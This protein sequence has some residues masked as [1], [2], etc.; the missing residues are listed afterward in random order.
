MALSDKDRQE[1]AELE[2]LDAL[3]QRYG[4]K[5]EPSALQGFKD[6]AKSVAEGVSDFA[7]G[8]TQGILMNGA[9]E[10][11]GLLT[12]LMDQGWKLGNKLGLAD[13]SPSQVNQ[14]LKDAGYSGDIGPTDFSGMFRA[15][16]E[17]S[18]KDFAAAQERSPWLY[19]AGEIG[20]AIGTGIATGGAASVGLA[21]AGV[22]AMGKTALKEALKQGGKAGLAKEIGKRA[23]LTAAVAAPEGA[24]YG[25]LGSEG[26]LINATPEEREKLMNDTIQGTVTGSLLGGGI[27]AA[28]D[29]L[30]IAGKYAGDKLKQFG[31]HLAKEQPTIKRIKLAHEEGK[32]GLDFTGET[33]RQRLADENQRVT[34]DIIR[35][36]DTADG[37]LGKEVG[38]SVK[39]SN[40]TFSA[41]AAPKVGAV[42]Q[43]I[44]SAVEYKPG[45]IGQGKSDELL[46]LI[47][48]FRDGSIDAKGLYDLRKILKANGTIADDALRGD[49]KQAV[50]QTKQLLDTIPEFKTANAKFT[51]FRS[52]GSESVL[53]KGATPEFRRY[54][55][56]DKVA[57]IADLMTTLKA[58]VNNY[59]RVGTS[60]KPARE[61]LDSLGKSLS[62]FERQYPGQMKKL[63]GKT[64]EEL[65][66]AL[67]RHGD[68]EGIQRV[69]IGERQQ[70][71]G[72]DNLL[73]F[74][75]FLDPANVTFR[76]A[77]A[78]GKGQKFTQDLGNKLY[79]LAPEKLSALADKMSSSPAMTSIGQALKQAIDDGDLPKRNALLFSI[80]Q[81]PKHRLS[82]TE[83]DLG[84]VK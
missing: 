63:T 62:Q 2:E 40:A 46:G 45:L 39:N 5:P 32:K 78:L 84:E 76:G 73:G 56:S 72:L 54:Y 25:A 50:S 19:G 58:T 52:A 36:F 28:S 64:G 66:S 31:N 77:N 18:A 3:E 8:G 6:T 49:I 69:L 48:G 30:P 41:D 80:M 37:K 51:D 38:D 65:V 7:H 14:R 12:A 33:S 42:L 75:H 26:R 79:S 23:L 1:L 44:F 34:G 67:K 16:Q 9:D 21:K 20:G 24:A 27:S 74:A 57:P 81:N 68:V 35:A 71:V 83:E 53:N 10:G 60:A 59:G 47:E 22:S 82:L 29:I 15:G 55:Q 13:E 70:G 17:A 11:G 4:N 61:L 43:R